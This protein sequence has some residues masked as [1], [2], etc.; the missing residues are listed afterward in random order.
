MR[1]CNKYFRLSDFH[2]NDYVQG[3]NLIPADSCGMNPR[4]N[5]PICISTIF[6]FENVCFGDDSLRSVLTFLRFV[7]IAERSFI[8]IESGDYK[9]DEEK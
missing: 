7:V 5:S 6:L 1:I 4:K 3:R 9:K 2:D 8:Y